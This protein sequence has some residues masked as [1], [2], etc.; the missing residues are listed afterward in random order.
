MFIPATKKE[1]AALGWDKLDIILIT[2]DAYIDSS[3][4][5]VSVIGKVLLNAGYRVGIIAQPDINSDNDIKT[6]GEPELFWGVTSGCVDSMVSNYT[7][8]KKRRKSDDFTPGGKNEKRP[9]RAVIAYSNLIRKYF[10]NTKPIVLGGIEASLRRIPHYDYWDNKIR[11]SILFD[12]KA[13]FL[14]YGM[15]EKTTLEL[16]EALREVKDH[17]KIRGL[18]YISQEAPDIKKTITLSSFDEVKSNKERFSEM[19]RTFYQNTDPFNAKTI[20]QKQDTRYLVLNR[21]QFPVTEKELD[22]I[23]SHDYE[24]DAHP[25]DKSQGKIKALD[26]IRFS[27]TSHRG[28]YGECSFCAITV[29]QGRIVQSRSEDSIIKEAEKI[30]RLP[31]FKGI[32]LDIGGPTANMY[33]SSCKRMSKKGACTDKSCL[34]PEQCKSLEV[35]HNQ[36]VK[37]LRKLSKIKGIKKVFVASGIRHDLVMNDTDSGMLY[38]EE[39]IK[40]HTSGQ[41]KTAPEHLEEKVLKLMRK[42]VKKELFEFKEK[43]FSF[44]KKHKKKQFLTYYLIAAHPGCD[45]LA[46]KKMRETAIKQLKILPEQV[47]IFTPT[48]STYSTLMY[49]CE[50]DPFQGR[51]IFVEKDNRNKEKQKTI[52][53]GDNFYKK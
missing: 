23:Y 2:G 18:A 33:G 14:V 7:A 8:V 28:C 36:Q 9:D 15:G 4:I 17:S 31:N 45:N 21:P 32:L 42:S 43:F 39:I 53:T 50:I 47:Q 46:M 5:G 38:L 19:F 40:D 29:H 49:Y 30:T 24:R 27:V 6:F 52:I 16:A 51:K 13:D 44:T 48:P 22:E 34:Y 11:R 20:Y 37:L 26:T 12:A 10:K 1:T 41:L 35:N 3:F 25:V